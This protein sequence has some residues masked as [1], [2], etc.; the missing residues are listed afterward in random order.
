MQTKSHTLSLKNSVFSCPL[1]CLDW[2]MYEAA[3]PE[4][5][6]HDY[7]AAYGRR[8]RGELGENEMRKACKVSCPIAS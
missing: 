6:R 3:I 2:A 8:L 4:N 5:E 7:V 1:I